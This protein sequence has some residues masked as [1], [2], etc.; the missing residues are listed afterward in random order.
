M[1]VS[2]TAKEKTM[3]HPDDEGFTYATDADFDREGARETG[4]ENAK[5]AWILS[6]R[7]VWYANPFYQGP[8]QRHPEDDSDAYEN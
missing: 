3:V 1:A 4:R 2:N 5:H 7:D 6:D 8:P